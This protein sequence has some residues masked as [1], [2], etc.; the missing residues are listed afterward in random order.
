MAAERF[1]S[2]LASM[3]SQKKLSR[4]FLAGRIFFKLPARVFFPSKKAVAAFLVTLWWSYTELR[5]SVAQTLSS[6]ARRQST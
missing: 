5:F 6:H 4:S 3:K 1:L 2:A